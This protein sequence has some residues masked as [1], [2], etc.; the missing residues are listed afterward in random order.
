[1]RSCHTSSCGADVPAV[2]ADASSALDA[3]SSVASDVAAAAPEAPE[4][5]AT[6]SSSILNSL[7]GVSHGEAM[8]LMYTCKVCETRSARKI[9]KVR[10]CRVLRRRA[11]MR[12]AT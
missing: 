3:S 4:A 1:M 12:P 8:V 11:A 7:P 2:A 10:S 6:A 9:S 5:P